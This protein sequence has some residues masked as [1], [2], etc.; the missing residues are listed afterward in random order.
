MYDLGLL[1]LI[2]FV[3][4]PFLLAKRIYSNVAAAS[5]LNL[6]PFFILKYSIAFSLAFV[7]MISLFGRATGWVSMTFPLWFLMGFALKHPAF[8]M[9]KKIE[10]EER[11]YIQINPKLA[12]A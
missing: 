1:G 9:L 4:I 8:Y 7:L 2:P 11:S 12:Q 6:E 3:L 5:A 10:A